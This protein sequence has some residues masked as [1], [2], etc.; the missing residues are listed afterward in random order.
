MLGSH[1][2]NLILS[3]T[4]QGLGSRSGPKREVM[5]KFWFIFY[6]FF[7]EAQEKIMHFICVSHLNCLMIKKVKEGHLFERISLSFKMG[8]MG[9]RFSKFRRMVRQQ[10]GK[11]YIM[12]VCIS[13]LLN[14][15]KHS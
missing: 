3:R 6:G 1:M 12:R 7:P 5:L 2:L 9:R 13:M 15:D 10:R 8:N 11:F 14:W 4:N